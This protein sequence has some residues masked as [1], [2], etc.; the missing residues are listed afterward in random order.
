MRKPERTSSSKRNRARVTLA[1]GAGVLLLSGCL[2]DV[3]LFDDL[4][5]GDCVQ[6]K[7]ASGLT[8]DGGFEIVDCGMYTQGVNDAVYRVGLI[9]PDAQS[10]GLNCPALFRGVI[11]SSP[12][13]SICFE[14]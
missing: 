1:I 3:G 6:E 13:R 2:G 10:M 9:E 14:Y 12:D 8:R 7:Q 11:V 4:E 5:V